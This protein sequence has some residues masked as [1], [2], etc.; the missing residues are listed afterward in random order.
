MTKNYW[1]EK[2]LRN[3]IK[4]TYKTLD[5][6][7]ASRIYTSHLIGKDKNLVMHGGG[8]I[9][10]KLLE[11]DILGNQVDVLRVKGSGWD[12]DSLAPEGLPSLN[13]SK[14]RELRS[15]NK[16]NDEDLV[17][18][19]RN[20][21][22]N[23]NSPNPSIETLLHAF[24][25]EKFIEHTH[26][27]AFLF[28]A[29]YPNPERIVRQIFG[30]SLGIVPYVKPG[31]DLAKLAADIYDSSNKLE[32]LI[33]LH[34]G[35]FAWGGNAK[36]SYNKLISQTQR[37]EKW[38]NKNQKSKVFLS[39]DKKKKRRKE[40][41]SQFLLSLRGNLTKASKG[42]TSYVF[43]LRQ[44]NEID[45]FL[46]SDSSKEFIKKWVVTPDH[47][48][49][50]KGLPLYFDL[51]KDNEFKAINNK[52]ELF[53]KDYKD[54]F[55]KYS[56]GKN[57]TQ[58][59]P[60]PNL[61]WAKGLGL[62]GVSETLKGAQIASD[63]GE[64]TI[65]IFSEFIKSGKKFQSLDQRD[66]FEME[67]WSLEQAKL[68]NKKKSIFSGKVVLVTG[69]TGTIGFEIAKLFHEKGSIVFLSDKN[70]KLLREKI[71]YFNNNVSGRAVDL[72][73]KDA[74]EILIEECV[75]TFGGIDIVISNAGMAIE[76]NLLDLKE[77]EIKESFNLNYFS[78]LNLSLASVKAFKQQ[79]L[80]G[81]I[82]FNL[83]KQTINPGKGFGA[84]GMPK[85]ATL[86][87]L[88]QL[89]LEHGEDGIEVNGVNADRIRSGLLDEKMIRKRAKARK[90]SEREYMKSNLLKKEVEAIHVAQ[91]FLALASGKRTTGHIL[92]VDGGNV[93]ASLR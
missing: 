64:Q 7:L 63:L 46:N 89:S 92:T 11:E 90:L 80:G 81:K 41:T 24:I 19:Q 4:S 26:S 83:S 67:Y 12:L 51:L 86:G 49:R 5:S 61:I 17:N 25:P 73:S 53:N 43:D 59:S 10:V 37:L 32:G 23:S 66:L 85:L 79:G 15:L 52:V 21:L 87:L 35:H 68:A 47:I 65:N 69:A 60:T 38:I 8:N 39:N 57:L 93:A 40:K 13:L 29:N 91:A 34:H 33:L 76:G 72:T 58:L 77:S 28:L 50:T 14:I 44:S 88:R 31:F 71:G 54:Y 27:S 62:I 6:D 9:S 78:H 82:I 20:C 70:K 36:D 45:A 75:N 55:K 3:Y 30:D 42:D 56:K 48:I 74:A 2:E 1:K 18:Y 84:Y 22:L 16:L